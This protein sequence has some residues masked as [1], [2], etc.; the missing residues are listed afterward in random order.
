M[1]A[2]VVLATLVLFGA[3]RDTRP[4]GHAKLYVLA[5]LLLVAVVIWLIIEVASRPAPE[6]RRPGPTPGRW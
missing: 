1:V 5:A 2:G 4:S 6:R 3:V